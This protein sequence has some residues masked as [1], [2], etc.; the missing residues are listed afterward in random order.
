MLIGRRDD[1][2]Q[3]QQHGERTHH[4]GFTGDTQPRLDAADQRETRGE[5]P[6]PVAQAQ[7]VLY[8]IQPGTIEA[9]KSM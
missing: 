3:M 6:C 1:S 2:R 9:V 8:G 7:K 4:R 5:M